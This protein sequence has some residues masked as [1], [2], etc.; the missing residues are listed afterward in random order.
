MSAVLPRSGRAGFQVD[1]PRL[2][3][4]TIQAGFVALVAIGSL[5]LQVRPA[6]TAAGAS[7]GLSTER[8]AL[9]LPRVG[10]RPRPLGSAAH[11]DAAD[12]IQSQL[13]GAGVVT[14]VQEVVVL[15]ESEAQPYR[16]LRLR[17]VLGRISGR[18]PTGAVLL[19]AHYDSVPT[20]PGA[21]DD[22]ASVA[23][24][25][26]V[27]RTLAGGPPL[28]NDVIF[29]FDDGEESGMAGARAFLQS[30]PWAAHVLLALNFEARGSSGPVL[31]FET[32]GARGPLV[33]ELAAAV[34]A[35]RASSLFADVY[36]RMP[37]D[38]SL[39]VF[40]QAGIPGLNFAN[41][42]RPFAY[43]TS[44]DRIEAVDER[45][46]RHRGGYALALA[47]RLGDLPLPLPAGA[48]A[49]YFDVPGNV[50]VR[51]PRRWVPAI[52]AVLALLS[53][54]LMVA[55]V[56]TG[57][58]S[59]RSAGAALLATLLAAGCAYLVAWGVIALAAAWDPAAVYKV[60]AYAAALALL[61]VGLVGWTLNVVARR[62]SALELWA[63]ALSAWLLLLLASSALLPGASYL[64]ALPVAFSLAAVPFLIH[65]RTRASRVLSFLAVALPALPLAALVLPTLF[66]VAVGLKLR[67]L[68]VVAAAVALA[69][70]LLSVH[71]RLLGGRLP[72]A[73]PAAVGALGLAACVV[74]LADGGVDAGRPRPN[75]L[76][77]VADAD[78]GRSYW[79]TTDRSVDEW[80]R[81][82]V[83][84]RPQAGD[85]SGYFPDQRR[86]VLLGP[87]GAPG[88]EGPSLRVLEDRRS[89][90][91]RAI[92]AWVS[93]DG[94]AAD[95]SVYTAPD[96]RVRRAVA[97]GIPLP[98][99][100]GRAGGSTA[101][102]WSLRYSGL[103][104]R[105]FELFLELDPG[106]APVLRATTLSYELPPGPL[107]RPPIRPPHLMPRPTF[108]SDA[109][110]VTRSFQLDASGVE[111]SR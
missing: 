60:E 31:M 43:H 55:A 20:S 32:S 110:A 41:I 49:V 7:P 46:L 10:S 58:L 3:F 102:G 24:L 48:D 99:R 106:V 79:V 21:S 111:G 35:P 36:A 2:G 40:R 45:T 65:A 73:A 109:A 80:T 82:F 27:A 52:G 50:L 17:N 70:A 84:D 87:S 33:R 72:W 93:A 9:H 22:G 108:L 51:Y 69:A 29:L 53:A 18:E 68:P 56:R 28:R 13:A 77:H 88:R 67:G 74:L 4:A 89:P 63:G 57:R 90:E 97:D 42:G 5:V 8:A 39:S 6:T 105:G 54:G 11:R 12:Y 14:Q 91:A 66:H 62:V 38:T 95:I 76:G 86:P 92:R 64:A 15:Q 37:N 107:G 44:L 25:L 26:E 19:A 103:P 94:E 100:P 23:C 1:A 75:H 30:H 104:A 16:L 81:Q 101:A 96:V 47:R 83:G 71:G 59:V 34:P 61:V 78:T 85:V 98:P